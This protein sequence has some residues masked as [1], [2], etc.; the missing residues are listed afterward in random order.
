MSTRDV[1]EEAFLNVRCIVKGYHFC[2]FEV[3]A[4]EVL[5]ANKKRNGGENQEMRLKLLTVVVSSATYS[6]S[7]W[8]LFWPHCSPVQSIKMKC[9]YN[10]YV[11]RCDFLR[12]FNLQ[13]IDINLSI[14]CY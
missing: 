13:A 12:C 8:I 3:T 14:D 6:L 7:L 11:Q 1:R 9:V 4:G 10:Y 2:S 5:T